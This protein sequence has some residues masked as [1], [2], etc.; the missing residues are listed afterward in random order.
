[1]KKSSSNEKQHVFPFP[2]EKMPTDS[3]H[4]DRSSPWAGRWDQF[5]FPGDRNAVQKG[6]I[7]NQAAVKYQ[8]LTGHEKLWL[9][10]T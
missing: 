8:Y 6:R 1:M 10:R 5:A 9:P 3:D 2:E 7:Y 4:T